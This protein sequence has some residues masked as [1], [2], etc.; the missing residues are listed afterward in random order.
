MSLKAGLSNCFLA[1]FPHDAF[2]TALTRFFSSSLFSSFCVV[3]V[4]NH[5][6]I[7]LQAAIWDHF[8]DIE[9]FPQGLE[10][11]INPYANTLSGGEKNA[12]STA[13]ALLRVASVLLLD[14]PTAGEIM[15]TLQHG[16]ATLLLRTLLSAPLPPR[17]LPAQMSIV[18][19][20][21]LS[22]QPHPA[23]VRSLAHVPRI[24]AF[25]TT[26]GFLL[27]PALLAQAS[28]H[29]TRLP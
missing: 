9:K 6:H 18:D 23:V 8:T 10:T 4:G 24:S 11:F 28:T 2:L 16:F 21:Q 1:G 25:T 12:I 19:E 29:R 3:L 5:L 13:R 27:C 20:C 15:A 17:H 14:E 26:T 7:K 22:T